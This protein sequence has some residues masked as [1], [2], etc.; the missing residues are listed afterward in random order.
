MT[1]PLWKQGATKSVA[2]VDT[3][4]ERLIELLR[5]LGVKR[6]LPRSAVAAQLKRSEA[7]QEKPASNL[8]INRPETLAKLRASYQNFTRTEREDLRRAALLQMHRHL[9]LLAGS[10]NALAFRKIAQLS[11]ALEALLVELYTEPAKIT[12]SVVRTVAHS[13]ETLASLVDRRREFSRRSNNVIEYLSSGRRS[14]RATNDLL[15]G[16]ERPT[17][18]PDGSG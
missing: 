7:N 10:A 5:E 4:P 14:Y 15:R 1:R 6:E 12:A 8:S 2:K 9:R 11:T 13:I 3:T 18:M 17:F 16:W